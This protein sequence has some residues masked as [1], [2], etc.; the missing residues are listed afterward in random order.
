VAV[1][2]VVGGR[3]DEPS[4]RGA[5]GMCV[6]LSRKERRVGDEPE[7]GSERW[8]GRPASVAFGGWAERGCET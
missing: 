2:I 6:V 4:Q 5:S 7:Q 8:T 3:T 1:W